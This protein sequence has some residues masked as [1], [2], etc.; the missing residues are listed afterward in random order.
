MSGGTFTQADRESMILGALIANPDEIHHGRK[1]LSDN[2]AEFSDQNHRAIFRAMIGLSKSRKNIDPWNI[3]VELKNMGINI[4][5]DW[6]F[7]LCAALMADFSFTTGMVE[8]HAGYLQRRY[9]KRTVSL[10]LT[11]IIESCKNG[12]ELA[13]IRKEIINAVG[14]IQERVDTPV[15]KAG[16]YSERLLKTL[17]DRWGSQKMG[18]PASGITTGIRILDDLIGGIRPLELLVIGGRPGIGKTMLMLFMAL[19][20][21]LS[22]VN[23][24][25]W[26]LEMSAISII[27]RLIT[28]L[29]NL[30]GEIL[31]TG[32]F[33]DMY[34]QAGYRGKVEA[35]CI[36]LGGLPLWIYDK[37][38]P[39]DEIISSMY[40]AAKKHGIELFFVD[41]L[42]RIYPAKGEK[43]IQRHEQV[44]NAARG[45]KE[46]AKETNT[47]V[48]LFSQLNR[49]TELNV[50]KRPEL[51]NLRDSGGIEQ[52]AD[53]V[54]L[55]HRDKNKN[56]GLTMELDI[57][58]NRHGKTAMI[59][60]TFIPEHSKFEEM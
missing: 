31:R 39:I 46:F 53:I 33:R 14:M 25:M 20:A 26:S 56:G 58:K 23:V 49:G 50:D 43:H 16:D 8:T 60:L 28:N 52:E 17:A 44:G 21:A 32:D 7:T 42:Q 29:K 45:F 54:L 10:K 3:R 4:G 41:Y 47:A 15:K 6:G 38:G 5:G 51:S 59:P 2:G 48:V 27:E 22:G 55:L 11:S 34:H 12:H 1:I 35:G 37:N 36:E 57:A 24:G 13:E 18:L 9:M 30:N 40:V 19:K